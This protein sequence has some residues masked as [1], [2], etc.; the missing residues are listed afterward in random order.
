MT[1]IESGA[2]LRSFADVQ[3]VQAQLDTFATKISAV[4]AADAAAAAAITQ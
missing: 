3:A 1:V 2:T 4:E